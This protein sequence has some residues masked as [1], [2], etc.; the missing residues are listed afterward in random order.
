MSSED[1]AEAFAVVV[2]LAEALG[3]ESIKDLPGL[4][5]VDIDGQWKVS[6]NGH[7]ETVD[8]VPPFHAAVEFNG[9]P[10]G[11]FSPR[12]SLIAAGAAANEAAFIEAVKARI[13]R[14]TAVSS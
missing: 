6:V 3:V 2:M 8:F 12:G 7:K 11:I 10:A 5:T 9:W 1:I 13:A 14:E 4:W